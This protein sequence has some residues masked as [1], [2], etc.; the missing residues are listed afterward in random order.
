MKHIVMFRFAEG[1]FSDSV[2]LE[3]K[4][5]FAELQKALPE[6]ILSVN[7]QKNSVS[8]DQNYDLAAIMEIKEEASL[9][10][11][12]MHPI[13]TALAARWIPS[14]PGGHLSTM[15]KIGGDS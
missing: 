11:Y 12:L 10:R 14:S 4:Q 5:V 1:R 2:V 3:A 7:I 13:H 15:N 9:N 6:D 8:R